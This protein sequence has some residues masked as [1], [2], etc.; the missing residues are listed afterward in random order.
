MAAS[1]SRPGKRSASSIREVD[2]FGWF[3][4]DDQHTDFICQW[5]GE[6]RSILNGEDVYLLYA[7]QTDWSLVISDYTLK[8]AKKKEYHLPYVVFISKILVLQGVDISN[9]HK[10]FWDS[11]NVFDRNS[12]MSLGLV[13]T[14][15]GWCFIGEEDHVYSSGST[16]AANEE[17]TNFFPETNFETFAIDQF[18]TLNDKF[19]HLQRAFDQA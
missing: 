12:I 7:L 11:T 17:R 9:E 14:M 18:R 5:G 4:D 15:K 13:K 8:F 16:L 3:S 1:S 6:D 10:C 19:N 2:P